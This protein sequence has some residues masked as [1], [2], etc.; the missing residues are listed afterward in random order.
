MGKRETILSFLVFLLIVFPLNYHKNAMLFFLSTLDTV[1]LISA[2]AAILIGIGIF[3]LVG[4]YHVKKDYELIIERAGEY[5]TTLKQGTYF[6]MPI[7]YQRVGSYCVAPQARTYITKSGN[8]LS[9]T[10]KIED[11]KTFHYCGLK[12]ETIMSVIEKENSEVTLAVLQ[13]SFA[14]YG[15]KFINIQKANY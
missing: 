11:S 3:F 2:S 12:F 5:Y 15:L 14:K 9:V 4:I 7:A 10:Y 1:L 13:N 6:K 8:K